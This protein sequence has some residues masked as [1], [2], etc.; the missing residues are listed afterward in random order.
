[1]K[2]D[3]KESK[4]L[5]MT[6]NGYG[7][8]TKNK[9]YKIQKRGGSGIKTAKITKKTGNLMVGKVIRGQRRR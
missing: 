8:M 9:D 7:K 1:V 3:D 6:G 4:F 2:K 5:V